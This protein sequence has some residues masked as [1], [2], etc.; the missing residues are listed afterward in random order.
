MVFI[1]LT[2]FALG[3][4]VGVYAF[5]SF[6]PPHH[7]TKVYQSSWYFCIVF[8]ILAYVQTTLKSDALPTAANIRNSQPQFTPEDIQIFG[9]A[10]LIGIMTAFVGGWCLLNKSSSS[11]ITF[12]QS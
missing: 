4:F 5:A 11:S 12:E 8:V 6:A 2:D 9:L 7:A 1:T 3:L 10:V